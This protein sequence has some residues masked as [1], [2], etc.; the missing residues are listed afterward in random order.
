MDKPTMDNIQTYV[1]LVLVNIGLT[2]ILLKE[3][4]IFYSIISFAFIFVIISMLNQHA[5]GAEEG[6][7]Y[8]VVIHNDITREAGQVRENLTQALRESEGH[9]ENSK[10]NYLL[11]VKSSIY[12]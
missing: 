11:V 4:N 6:Q 8:F 12:L 2:I 10:K 1:Q 3:I 5:A 9:H 7:N